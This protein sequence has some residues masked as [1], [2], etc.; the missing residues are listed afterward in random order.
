M[1]TKRI[2]PLSAMASPSRH[3]HSAA[4]GLYGRSEKGFGPNLLSPYVGD[5][6]IETPEFKAFLVNI[7][8]TA[9]PVA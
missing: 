7:E 1:V 3:R 9:G 4:L 8:P 5:A 6:D 2:K